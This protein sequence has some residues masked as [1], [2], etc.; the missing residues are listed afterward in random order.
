MF[1]LSFLACEAFYI[2]VED[3]VIKDSATEPTP[4]LIID[5][6]WGEDVL[7]ISAKNTEGY[8]N[9]Q[10][11]II[12][13]SSE[14]ESDLV[15]GCWTGEDCYIGHTPPEGQELNARY[16]QCHDL[17]STD[18]EYGDNSW[19]SKL[20]YSSNHYDDII[21]IDDAVENTS[22]TVGNGFT[23]F[24]APTADLSYETMVTY[25]IK[26]ETIGADGVNP[27]RCW[28][29]GVDPSYFDIL[30]CSTPLPISEKNSPTIR[31]SFE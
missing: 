21:T 6:E 31:L 7:S 9:I 19:T 29:W 27:E 24:P 20:E 5:I 4:N 28:A 22:I 30:E 2:G 12:E 3:A 11:G 15:D 13:S 18:A 23:A 1:L 17:P 25:Y 26:A 14:C 10:F 16:N 8:D